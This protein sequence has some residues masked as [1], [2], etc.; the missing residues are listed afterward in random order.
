MTSTQIWTAIAHYGPAAVACAAAA[1][2]VLPK[3]APGTWYSVLRGVI[4]LLACN[5]GSAKNA[6]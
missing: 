6:P 2:A 3:P 5:F 1:A 4:D